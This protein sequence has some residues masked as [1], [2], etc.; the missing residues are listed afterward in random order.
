ML[1]FR[2]ISTLLIVVSILSFFKISIIDII[3][4]F[5]NR[6]RSKKR[7]IRDKVE[8]ATEK[9]RINRFKRL[10]WEVKAILKTTNNED[11]FILLVVLSLTSSV[12]GMFIGSYLNNTL[13]FFILGGGFALIPFW[14]V[15]FI[16]SF[17]KRELNA[18]LE[19]SLSL[20]T[21]SYIRTENIILAIS[22][23]LPYLNSPVKEIFEVFIAQTTLINSNTKKALDDLKYKVDSA[24][25]KEWVDALI[26]CQDNKNLKTTLRPITDKLSDMR[27]VAA[28]LDNLVYE[29]VKEFCLM[30][31]LVVLN[32]PIVGLLS[33][34]LYDQIM[35]T[36]PGKVMVSI[37]VLTVFISVARVISLSK[38]I[39]YRR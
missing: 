14:Y 30:V 3:N 12:V 33:P 22:E 35:H 36:T 7:T 6:S 16:A 9:K 28:E 11:K 21:N 5:E 34:S 13:L 15:K 23:N 10:T 17:W 24:V 37:S 39:E 20:I 31:I 32:I 8:I 4:D 25:F 38:P 29:P 18:E 1:A 27:V 2:F 26:S 19:T